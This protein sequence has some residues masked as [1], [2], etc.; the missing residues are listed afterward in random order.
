[1]NCVQR[2]FAKERVLEHFLFGVVF[3]VCETFLLEQGASVWIERL[4]ADSLE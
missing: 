3:D 4:T 1:M 2:G